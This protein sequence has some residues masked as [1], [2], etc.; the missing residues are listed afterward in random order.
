M[1]LVWISEQ[2]AIIS[3]YSI[4][5][6]M[7]K[8]TNECFYWGWILVF[9]Y[10]LNKFIPWFSHIAEEVPGYSPNSKLH[11]M[12]L[13]QTPQPNQLFII[14][15]LPEYNFT[16][17]RLL[18]GK[19]QL[20]LSFSIPFSHTL[21]LSL[22]LSLFLPFYFFLFYFLSSGFKWQISWHFAASLRCANSSELSEITYDIMADRSFHPTSPSFYQG[23]FSTPKLTQTGIATITATSSVCLASLNPSGE[24]RQIASSSWM[25][26][27]Q[28]STDD[29]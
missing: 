24:V 3:L 6:L 16:K 28:C 15:H 10:N 8:M 9:I 19:S 5:W 29:T 4:N 23:K 13:I 22:S 18:R 7:L 2:T 25:S 20:F 1:C 27:T 14:L 12:L 11:Y 21:S 17:V 26:L